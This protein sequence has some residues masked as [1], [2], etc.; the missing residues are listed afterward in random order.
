MESFIRNKY[1]RKQYINKN[2]PPPK[3]TNSTQEAPSLSKPLNEAKIE[4]VSII[5]VLSNSCS[6]WPSNHFGLPHSK[7]WFLCLR[8]KVLIVL[9]NLFNTKNKISQ[10]VYKLNMWMYLRRMKQLIKINLFWA[11]RVN[12]QHVFL[13]LNES[14][15]K[16]KI[17]VWANKTVISQNAFFNS[18]LS[19]FITALE[20]FKV[21]VYFKGFNLQPWLPSCFFRLSLSLST[22][23]DCHASWNLSWFEEWPQRLPDFVKLFHSWFL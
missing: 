19:E 11:W 12:R 2:G 20:Q 22:V 3:I 5:T 10:T 16:P 21:T 6:R 1:E 18:N 7:W 17:N 9:D 8:N 4:R 13:W 23:L 14:A 15:M